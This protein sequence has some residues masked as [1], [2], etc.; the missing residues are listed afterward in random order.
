MYLIACLG[1]QGICPREEMSYSVSA[2]IVKQASQQNKDLTSLLLI[3]SQ[4]IALNQ[5]QRFSYG[6]SC[7]LDPS[8]PSAPG[9]VSVD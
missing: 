9:I 7:V 2:W 8:I 1:T 5:H 4:G 3:I 6:I